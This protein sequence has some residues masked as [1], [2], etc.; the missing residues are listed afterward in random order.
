VLASVK[1]AD[2]SVIAQNAIERFRKEEID[3]LY[4]LNNEFKSVMAQKLTVTRVL[5]IELAAE[6]SD[7]DYIFEQPPA[8][9]LAALLPQ[10]VESEVYRG[11]LESVA[12]EHAARMTAMDAATSN[13]ADMIER[14]TLYRTRAAG[15]H[16]K[17]SSKWSA[18]RGRGVEGYQNANIQQSNR[19]GR[20]RWRARLWTANSPKDRFPHPHRDPY[21]QRGLQCARPD[22]YHLRRTEQHIGEGRVRTIALQPTEGLVRGMKA[23]SSARRSWCRSE[24]RLWAACST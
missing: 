8:E 13:A 19:Q 15:Q 21:H 16:P 5:P 17:R 2:A 18:A 14:L 22:R 6:Q 12:A 1:F 11:M 4:L 23:E 20:F 9:L 3:A 7:I 24:K 10:Y